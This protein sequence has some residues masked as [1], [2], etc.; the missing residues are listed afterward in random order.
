MAIT[1]GIDCG[2]QST[3][4]L[5]YDSQTKEVLIVTTSS[6]QL[7]SKEDGTREQKASWFI[8]AIKDCFNQIPIEIK[9]KIEAI[10]VSG[11]QHGFVAL[12]KDGEPLHNVKLWCDTSTANYCDQLTKKLGG[13]KKVFSLISN[14][15]LP[16]YTASK[17]L[18]LKENH[19]S[20]YDKLAHILLPHDYINYYL[21]GEYVMEE[22][23]AS[24]TAFFDVKNRRFCDEVLMAIDE[25]R[26]LKET[27]P[28]LVKSTDVIGKIRKEVAD[29]LKI[30]KDAIVSPGGGDNM[31]GA[32]GAGCTSDGDLVMSL[33]TS[34]TL[35]GY[36]EK[37]IADSKN[38]LAAFISSSGG[39]LPLLCTMNCTV[40]T[41]QLRELL[42]LGV[43]ELDEIANQSKPGANG[44]IFLP[45][46]NGERT[47]NYPKAEAVIA[48]M[49]TTNTNRSNIA[50]ASLESAI[51][52]MQVGLEAFKEQGFKPSKIILI[53]GG[54]KSKVW[55]QI[56][57]DMFKLKVM[58]P[59]ISETAAL[60]GALQSLATLEKK[61]VKEITDIHT[62]FNEDRIF[63]PNEDNYK[64]YEAGYEKYRKYDSSLS[65]L[66]K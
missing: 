19:K 65:K 25:E 15:I 63:T 54:A 58:T 18:Y 2:T 37:L 5:C 39:Y 9:E 3:K 51:Y 22:G 35:F 61:T 11:Q 64:L 49:N 52:S 36:S 60:G 34:G 6:H 13:D 62:Q 31:M 53:G 38:R 8:D 14:Q 10:G 45:Y 4:V 23:D 20:E 7:I 16:G 12:D 47:P 24:G 57:S 40:A 46:F 66:F 42:Q 55:A 27:L 56:V 43:K 21:T 26:D 48:G 33:G 44:I 29:E 41:E 32:I 1:A 50:R 17:V 59:K 30:N 28:R